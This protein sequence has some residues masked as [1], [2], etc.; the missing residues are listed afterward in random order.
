MRRVMPLRGQANLG[1]AAHG[2]LIQLE[3]GLTDADRHALPLLA[4]DP[5]PAIQRKIAAHHGDLAH[6]LW[7][8]ADKRCALDAD[9][10]TQGSL[11][12][13]INDI[14][15]F[16]SLSN[17]IPMICSPLSLYLLYKDFQ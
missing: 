9:H 3:R 14:H 5:D 8:V 7:A 16:L 1:S 11:L 17:E 4:T 2:E 10:C 15:S 12:S 6:G 13:L